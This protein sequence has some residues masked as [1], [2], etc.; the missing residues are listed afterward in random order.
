MFETVQKFITAEIMEFLK[1]LRATELS[2]VQ[3]VVI[4]A[5][6]VWF[7]LLPFLFLI[8][9]KK[10]RRT[11]AEN[12]PPTRFRD[13]SEI[14]PSA[15]LESITVNLED[16]ESDVLLPAGGPAILPGGEILVLNPREDRET[17]SRR[18]SEEYALARD[19]LAHFFQDKIHFDAQ[20]ERIFKSGLTG[21]TVINTAPS[22]FWRDPDCYFNKT[23]H[24]EIGRI[25]FALYRGMVEQDEDIA[26]PDREA[27]R[28]HAAVIN[29]AVWSGRIVWVQELALRLVGRRS[30]DSLPIRIATHL[31]RMEG[32]DDLAQYLTLRC[33]DGGEFG[34][35]DPPSREIDSQREDF[36]DSIFDLLTGGHL[37]R[38]LRSL[39]RRAAAD[40]S[41]VDLIL[42]LYSTNGKEDHRLYHVLKDERFGRR[43]SVEELRSILQGRVDRG[44]L[45]SL[46]DEFSAER[47][48]NG[49]PERGSGA[50]DIRRLLPDVPQSETA[51]TSDWAAHLDELRSL[52][53]R[54]QSG[55]SGYTE[56]LPELQQIV[57]REYKSVDSP[58]SILLENERLLSAFVESAIVRNQLEV[59]GRFKMLLESKAGALINGRLLL[60]LIEQSLGNNEE[61]MRLLKKAPRQPA[62]ER[63]L[64]GLYLDFGQYAK[65]VETC[66]R[67]H[68]RFPQSSADLLNLGLCLQA[69]GEVEE[70]AE[71]I[72]RAEEM[73]RKEERSP[74][75]EKAGALTS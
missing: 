64:V 19:L 8:L 14:R 50:G 60:G 55:L 27:R 35:E 3:L 38:A 69:A 47:K 17:R 23:V 75:P 59:V 5:L 29:F 40:A 25:I 28:I 20:S 54:F 62:G 32:R 67:L 56:R 4:A 24:D 12:L 49:E 71:M 58:E 44:E 11:K 39:H 57:L 43:V 13:F 6:L 63:G 53:T 34:F 31:S 70:G 66:R 65:A 52:H 73:E 42:H 9:R 37:Y 10:D 46:V 15:E 16:D 48:Y 41:A 30:S 61:A 36:Y 51:Q 45:E 72:R 22:V 68:E 74:L 2:T 7:I 18:I 1:L 26:D 33:S 21:R